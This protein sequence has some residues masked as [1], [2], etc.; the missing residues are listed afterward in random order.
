MARLVRATAQGL[1]HLGSSLVQAHS[2]GVAGRCD[3]AGRTGGLCVNRF[4][5]LCAVAALAAGCDAKPD[6]QTQQVVA[7][8]GLIGSWA[9]DCNP[10]PATFDSGAVFAVEADGSVS[11]TSNDGHG[12]TTGRARLSNA[13][14]TA[15]GQIAFDATDSS[16]VDHTVMEKNAAGQVRTRD[17]TGADGTVY[18]K[19]GAFPNGGGPNWLNKCR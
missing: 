10:P 15:P 5:L 3:P 8:F 4:F 2:D 13:R 18:V 9:A 16:G 19:D 7:A 14:I 12:T 17:N 6:P 1:P 11:R